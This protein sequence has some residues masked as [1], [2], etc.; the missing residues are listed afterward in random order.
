MKKRIIQLMLCASIYLGAIAQDCP[1]QN[2]G[3]DNDQYEE[4]IKGYCEE[5][6]G[7]STDP[8]NLA[9]P[10]CPNL[11]N[12]F[13][14]R[15]KQDPSIISPDPEFYGVYDQFGDPKSVRN[16]FNDPGNHEYDYIANNHNSNYHPE[17]GWE[18]LKVDF[19]AE[20]N[21]NTGWTQLPQDEP[22]LN[23]KQGGAR[24]P[25]MIL[26]NKYSGTFRFFGSLLGETRGHETVRIELRIP[27]KSPNYL[28]STNT[29]QDLDATNLLSV[30]GD[31][32]QPLDQETEENVMVVFTKATNTATQFFW[33]DIPVAYDP[34]LCN[35]RSQLDITFA[36]IATASLNLN[37]TIDGAIETQPNPETGGSK[38]VKVATTVLAAGISTALAVKTGGAVINFQAYSDLIKLAKD[39]PGLS[40]TQKD[41]IEQLGNYV[42]CGLKFAK[43]IKKDY[44]DVSASGNLTSAQQKAKYKAANNILEANTTFMS[45]LA[46]GCNKS[47][48][49]GTTINGTV[50]LSGT[51]TET[52]I[53]GQTE[54]LMALPGSN[55]TDFEM[56]REPYKLNGLTVP[57]Y[58]EY[59]ERLGTFILL[60]TPEINVDY[61]VG[62][63]YIAPPNRDFEHQPI[64]TELEEIAYRFQLA[65]SPIKIAFNPLMKL[66]EE[67][68]IIQSR[69]VVRGMNGVSINGQGA[70][71]NVRIEKQVDQG[72]GSGLNPNCI[73]DEQIQVPL[74]NTIHIPN[75]KYP[76]ASPFVPIDQIQG[77]NGTFS[78]NYSN[79]DLS[80]SNEFN[81]FLKDNIFIQIRVVG[82]SINIG[83]D[84]N[85]VAFVQTLTFP[86]KVVYNKIN[87]SLYQSLLDEDPEFCF[88]MINFLDNAG[89]S[90][91]NNFANPNNDPILTIGDKFYDQDFIFTQDETIYYDGKVD[92][93]AKLST[94]GNSQIT[95]YAS[96]G[97]EIQNGGEVNS[98]IELVIGYPFN[99]V[100]FA[101]QTF[102]QVKGFCNN[103]TKYKANIFASEALKEE[104]ETYQARYEAR[105]EEMEKRRKAKELN[106][107]LFPNPTKDNFT[108]KFDYA[109]EDVTVFVTD[110]NG[111][112]V[113]TKY[114]SGTQDKVFIDARDLEAGVYFIDIRTA[115]GK[116]GRERLV[117]Y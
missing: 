88:E 23:T 11:E 89:S 94:L 15:I 1:P 115:E 80:N 98:N 57:A 19:G 36:F 20:S 18:L 46:N 53:F 17:D 2:I 60:E 110:I 45:S 114:F 9:N 109:L 96:E 41:N 67:K 87:N 75:S 8:D 50:N 83:S 6:N 48:N 29:Y 92:I 55:W 97:L 27:E 26:Y 65:N 76:I 47:D 4:L 113:S 103:T 91:I 61:L 39:I 111:K 35:I 13:E 73:W 5:G 12:D 85:P 40:T 105:L 82:E 64:V 108:I 90:L 78:L 112:Q 38:G 31:A 22:G 24:L 101:P 21:F 62:E 100:P 106:L 81:D 99:S 86:L 107:S 34:C 70:G 71:I 16:P 117:K 33:F 116:I 104:E 66:N 79:N 58:P 68:S 59:N 69:I 77:V 72:G 30:Q 43:V 56:D 42:D 95:I 32:V 10:A 84:G 37:G 102:E 52:T 25:Y 7:I 14:W 54:I 63:T 3:L 74:I 49:A 28:I 44:K 93:S 51:W